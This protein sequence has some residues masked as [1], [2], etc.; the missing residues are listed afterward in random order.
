MLVV[1]K[2]VGKAYL[3]SEIQLIP[4]LLFSSQGVD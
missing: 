2:V 3:T 1:S 4:T